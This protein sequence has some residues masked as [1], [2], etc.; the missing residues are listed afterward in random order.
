MSDAFN[1]ILATLLGDKLISNLLDRRVVGVLF[2]LVSSVALLFLLL[3]VD[4]FPVLPYVSDQL[5]SVVVAC[6]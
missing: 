5:A 2:V 3:V 4:V 6:V 1:L